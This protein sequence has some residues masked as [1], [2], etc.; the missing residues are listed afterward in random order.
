MQSN[1]IDSRHLLKVQ[2]AITYGAT[3]KV[4]MANAT[5]T[6]SVEMLDQRWT[7]STNHRRDKSGGIQN[8]GS[9]D[10]EPRVRSGN[11][12]SE[13]PAVTYM[14]NAAPLVT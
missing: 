9:N 4:I 14:P 7:I 3:A 13:G 11:S 1:L 5:H 8:N 12:Q 6:R 10:V 2:Q